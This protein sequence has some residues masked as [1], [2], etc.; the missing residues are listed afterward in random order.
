MLGYTEGIGTID[1]TCFFH[2]SMQPLENFPG[3]VWLTFYF[4]WT[5][6]P[7]DLKEVPNL[8]I[9]YSF[10]GEDVEAEP[11]IQAGNGR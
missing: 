4:H 11:G 6:V 9:I 2:I 7:S 5:A 1:F 3:L 8:T 10:L